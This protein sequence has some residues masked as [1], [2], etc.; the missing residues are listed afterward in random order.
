MVIKSVMLPNAIENIGTAEVTLSLTDEGLIKFD[1]LLGMIPM[2]TEVVVN[3]G[4]PGVSNAGVFY[5]DSNGLAMQRR[6]VGKRPSY[7]LVNDI[8]VQSNYYPV[9]TAIAIRD[10]ETQMTVMTSHTQG[11]TSFAEGRVELM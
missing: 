9:T 6:E 7:Y 4:A 11:G 3:F 8:N 10:E 1:V 2:N 5:T